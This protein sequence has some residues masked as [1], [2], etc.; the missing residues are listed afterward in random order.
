MIRKITTLFIAFLFALL[1]P[2]SIRAQVAVSANYVLDSFLRPIVTAKLCF[3]PV[4]AAA[5]PA[6]FRVGSIQ[7]LPGQVCG[8]VSN[9]VMQSGIAVAPTPTGIYYHIW[10]ASRAAGAV[11]RDLGMT[12]ITGSSWTLDTYDPASMA[13]LP[14]AVTMGAVTTLA[15]GSSAACTISG[16]SPYYLNCGIP[17]GDTGAQGPAGTGGG[18]AYPGVTADGANGIIVRGTV[19]AQAT[20][21]QSATLTGLETVVIGDSISAGHSSVGGRLECSAAQGVTVPTSCP[22]PNYPNNLYD[23]ALPNYY[24]SPAWFLQ[25]ILGGTVY[26]NGIGG[27]TAAHTVA[28]WCRDVLAQTPAQGCNVSDSIGAT[29]TLP[30][31][32]DVV[33]LFVGV[34]DIGSSTATGIG[35]TT[36][37]GYFQT[38]ITSAASN[39][40]KLIIGLIPAWST[41][42]SGGTSRTVQE[43]V[44]AWLKTNCNSSTCIVPE[45]TSPVTNPSGTAYSFFTQFPTKDYQPNY[46]YVDY[47]SGVANVIHPSRTG[48]AEYFKQIIQPRLQQSG[49]LTVM[50]VPNLGADL[51]GDGP[52]S[53]NAAGNTVANTG[54][55]VSQGNVYAKTGSFYSFVNLA[56]STYHS[57]IIDLRDG[58][59]GLTSY[60]GGVGEYCAGNATP[61]TGCFQGLAPIIT[62]GAAATTCSVAFLPASGAGTGTLTLA[63][64]NYISSDL[65]GITITAAGNYVSPPT[66]ATLSNG[67]ATCSGTILVST[68]LSGTNLATAYNSSPNEPPGIGS[69]LG[70]NSN[71]G[72]VKLNQIIAAD[73]NVGGFAECHV[74][75]GNGSPNAAVAGKPCDMYWEE[76]GTGNGS[77]LW[78]WEN[79]TTGTGSW[80]AV[81]TL[82][83]LATSMSGSCTMTNAGV[84]SCGISTVPVTGSLSSNVS[85]ATA[86]TFYDGPSIALTAGTWFLS[87]TITAYAPVENGT[88]IVCK[89]WDG[90][91]VA[92]SAEGWAVTANG[93]VA[94]ALSGVASPIG[95]ATWKIS[96]TPTAIGT[97]TMTAASPSYGSGNN[98]ST[99]SGTRVH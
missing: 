94:I 67:T 39:N 58:T 98:A 25:Q 30:R 3:A 27:T 28:R 33:F 14:Q 17:K 99:L 34:N 11:L 62:T 32:A 95:A 38:I 88:D 10:V 26:N 40:I 79:S 60:T 56:T 52:I 96:C 75:Y 61:T 45:A 47:Q 6:G 5:N 93:I 85:M 77:T 31:Q 89:L 63:L 73:A 70:N 69:Y 68:T 83:S 9:G 72:A 57:Q 44:N 29:V 90:T 13:V 12:P 8:L 36:L 64:P 97:S 2:V 49:F 50:P 19:A 41:W 35:A 71:Y 4:D 76:G 15:P 86:G 21:A 24:G 54:A 78:V 84:M 80:Y 48:F 74:K 37:E 43:T 51:F 55:F 91:T 59:I 20:V 92:A 66:S 42:N 18:G 65:A 23:L 82:Q 53:I 46:G 1:V 81:Q 7:I 16:S 87:G 22:S